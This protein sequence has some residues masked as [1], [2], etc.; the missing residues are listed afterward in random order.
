MVRGI[1]R[2]AIF[3]DDVDRTRFLMRLD[4]ALRAAGTECLAWALMPNHVHLFLRT[5]PRPLAVAMHVLGTT[6]VMDFNRRHERVGHLF[7]NRYKALPVE[8]DAYLLELIRYIHLNPVRAGIVPDVEALADH[9]W[10]GHRALMGLAV[11]EFQSVRA[12]L[13]L[14]AVNPAEAR[15]KLQEWMKAPLPPESVTG[16][17]RRKPGRKPAPPISEGDGPV[18]GPPVEAVPEAE[19]GTGP[20]NPRWIRANALR[21]EGWDLP[22][23]TRHICERLGTP[24][25][26]V[27]DGRR[28]RKVSAARAVIAWFAWSDLAMPQSALASAL[29][30]GASALSARMERGRLTAKELGIDPFRGILRPTS[31]LSGAG[32]PVAAEK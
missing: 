16:R 2:R 26:D 11:N 21:Q 8:S 12:V 4:S 14:M 3:M 24:A 27:Q 5:G 1:E 9:P 31:P 32:N 28:S 17:R 7:Q 20:A 13:S 6:Y 30:V 15:I 23:L 10:T 29:G 25:E 18:E 19:E 22:R